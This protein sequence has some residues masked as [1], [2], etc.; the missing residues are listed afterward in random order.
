MFK[1][2]VNGLFEQI[3]LCSRVICLNKQLKHHFPMSSLGLRMLRLL[4][5]QGL[6]IDRM[7]TVSVGLIVSRLLYVLP[8][9]SVLV[10]AGQA[11]RIDAF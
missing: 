6:S 11:G 9:W 7:N 1:Q 2:I 10:S 3:A 5:S 4:R 8:A